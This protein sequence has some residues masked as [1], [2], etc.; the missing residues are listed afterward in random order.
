MQRLLTALLV[1]VLFAGFTAADDV[2]VRTD[3]TPKDL[4]RVKAVTA[5]TSDFSKPEQFE[6]L[7]GG[8]ATTKKLVNRDIFSQF[9]AN[10]SF[11]EQEQFSLGNGFFRKLW[12]SA[13]ASTQG[14][15]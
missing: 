5:L 13:P 15:D 14:S 3:L 2:A 12:V 11:D 6:R 1:V 7:P 4:A 9:S 8:A 10:L